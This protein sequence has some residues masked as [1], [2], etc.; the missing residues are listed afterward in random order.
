MSKL[1]ERLE[2]LEAA[3][4]NEKA[5]MV[6]DTITESVPLDNNYLDLK[7]DIKILDQK[8]QE[9]KK[10]LNKELSFAALNG[11]TAETGDKIVSLQREIE[12][13]QEK[14]AKNLEA[15][16]NIEEKTRSNITAKAKDVGDK[17]TGSINRVKENLMDKLVAGV[18]ATKAIGSKVR[19]ANENIMERGAVEKDTL[20]TNLEESINQIGRNW[21]SFN[22]EK[23]RTVSDTLDKIADTM[24]KFFERG[25][26]IK[27]AFK[28]LGRAL[29]G[30][31]RQNEKGSLSDKQKGI[32]EV[33]R[34]M[35]DGL[36]TE[37]KDLEK[38]FNLS[39][40]LSIANLKGARENREES[41]H[42]IKE[43][44]GLEKRFAQAK[45]ASI[46]AKTE[47]RESNREI[48]NKDISI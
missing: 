22:Y 31:E 2:E 11:M 35:A 7:R 38:E 5:E 46:S 32:V 28:D 27:E 16:Q 47:K 12:I 15:I 20:N 33:V 29:V 30:R 21:M 34:I 8:M 45:E 39:K 9:L 23:D 6:T 41:K 10:E 13:S 25:A 18:S 42:N 14:T 44:S 48:G 43:N 19:E 3:L 17:I 24:E 26:N 40:E 37:M 1:E 36:R 4:N